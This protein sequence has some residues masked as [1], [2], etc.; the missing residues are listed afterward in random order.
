MDAALQGTRRQG[1]H[2]YRCLAATH[3]QCHNRKERGDEQTRIPRRPVRHPG[4]RLRSC[5]DVRPSHL[6]RFDDA[7]TDI[8]LPEIDFEVG[9]Y[10][11]IRI[12]SG[13]IQLD[14]NWMT[15]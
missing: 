1:A 9:K 11:S 14:T 6:L 5:S 12:Y 3:E 7:G 10:T 8:W 13:D 4:Q 15:R 2:A